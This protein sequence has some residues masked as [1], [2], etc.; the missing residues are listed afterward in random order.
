MKRM[1][2]LDNTLT[3]RNV[4]EADA[5][6]MH[7]RHQHLLDAAN[8]LQTNTEPKLVNGFLSRPCEYPILTSHSTTGLGI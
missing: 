5:G 6:Q 3:P 1:Y 4:L 8:F 2:D 7:M